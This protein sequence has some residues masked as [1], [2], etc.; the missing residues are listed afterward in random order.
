[1]I[2]VPNSVKRTS[3][4]AVLQ[5]FVRNGDRCDG[6][7][8]HYFFKNGIE[9]RQI[10]ST[11]AEAVVNEG[12]RQRLLHLGGETY[13]AIDGNRSEPI[14]LSSSTC[15]FCC[16]SGCSTML[17][18]NIPI[19][20]AVVSTAAPSSGSGYQLSSPSNERPHTYKERNMYT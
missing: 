7:P 5:C 9:V 14:T 17:R 3:V 15:A 8:S 13:S 1:V 2:I 20:A 4:L 19:V 16:I 6:M 18:T 12:R 11:E 10:F